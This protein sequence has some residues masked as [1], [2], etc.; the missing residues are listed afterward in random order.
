MNG[1]QQ[2]LP[3]S[4]IRFGN[5]GYCAGE[6]GDFFWISSFGIGRATV[7]AGV[8]TVIFFAR[9]GSKKPGK[10]PI[11]KQPKGGT[12]VKLQ[13]RNTSALRAGVLISATVL[14]M[15]L[16]GIVLPDAA[17]LRLRSI[18]GSG[19]SHIYAVMGALGAVALLLAILRRA[20]E[21]QSQINDELL[22]AFLDHVP[23]NVYFK[24][25]NSRFVRVSSS[26]ARHFGLKSAA[27]AVG[28][29]DA[30]VFTAEHAEQALADEREVIRTGQPVAE[31]EEKETWPDGRESWVLT[32]K[33]P[34]RNRFGQIIGTMGIS[35]NISDR[36]Q[37]E[38]RARHMALHDSL[39]G[40]PN[41]ALLLDS[42]TQGIAAS[43]RNGSSLSVL[44]L[45][46]DRFKYVNDSL[47]HPV[48][49][50]V[51]ERVAGRLK[52]C[53][54][55]GDAV[56]RLAGDEFVVA[57]PD[58][59]NRKAVERVAQ[60]I[61]TTIAE[62]LEVG[63]HELQLT[64]SIGISLYPENGENPEALLQYADSAM[65][66]AKKRGRGRYSFFSPAL[67]EATQKQQT[68]EQDLL[69]ACSWDEFQLYYQPI[70]ESESGQITGMEALLR[71]KHPK[72]G[73]ISPEQFIPQLEELGL[74]VET[75]RWILRTS[76]RK[77]AEWKSAGLSPVR[78]AVNIS[79]QQFYES[80]IVETVESVLRETGLDP[81]QLELDLTESRILEDSEGMILKMKRL[82]TIGVSLS[83]DNFGT[84]WSSLSYLRR[85]PVDRIRIDRS[86]IRDVATQPAAETM[87]KGILGMARSLG[88]SSIAEGV[89]SAQQKDLL[90]RLRCNELQGY[91]FS[92]PLAAMD[93]TALLRAA[94]IKPNLLL[95]N[96]GG[97]GA[98]TAFSETPTSS[99]TARGSAEK[100]AVQ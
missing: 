46:L 52:Q 15:G 50:Q 35:H 79:T 99:A 8:R 53:T 28:K 31:K 61:L 43:K 77:A 49:D 96:A 74:M 68:L 92:R 71:W 21:R 88:F 39:T 7:R 33:L 80:D 66:D 29:S 70:V 17:V 89:E 20:V 13:W 78:V 98:A 12:R 22:D 16:G 44:L 84:R 93:A 65:Y 63:D 4:Q 26:M 11:G 6:Q 62:P 36:R 100:T 41:R 91:Y 95:L 90:K 38:M 85:F 76:C 27:Q 25:L 82:R 72:E 58:L 57:V 54:R 73:L 5:R 64:A 51:L 32:T 94:M 40:L 14:G 97:R 10:L 47:G 18:S 81:K 24:D 87:V 75:G 3:A 19:Q 67:T 42:L 60:K 23:D 56:A 59:P 69:N 48:G 55:G 37:A 34:L 1:Y 2:V 83:L 30:E 45:D 9:A 86:F